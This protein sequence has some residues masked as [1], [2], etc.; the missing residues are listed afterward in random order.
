MNADTS[1][2]G[3]ATRRVLGLQAAALTLVAAGFFLMKGQWEA[4]SA[5]YGGSI[6]VLVAL[7]LSR[8]VARAAGA[9]PQDHKRSLIILYLGAAQRFVLVAVLFAAGLAALKLQPLPMIAGF[10]AAQLVYTIAMRGAG[11]AEH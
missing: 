11:R 4:L 1:E 5:A 10:I 9:A 6:S 7:L 2:I 8:G 3:S